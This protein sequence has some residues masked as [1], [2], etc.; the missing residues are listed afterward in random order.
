MAIS[1]PL[2]ISQFWDDLKLMAGSTEIEL[3]AFRKQSVDGAGNTLSSG[4]AVGKWGADLLVAPA[5]YIDSGKVEAMFKVLLGRDGT[6][7]AYDKRRPGPA[8]D[9]TGAILGAATVLISSKGSNNRSLALKGL[10][11]GY[12][13]TK[14]DRGSVSYAG[15]KVFYFEFAESGNANGSG[16]TAELEV[17]PFLPAAL[18][19]NDIVTLIKPCGKFKIV[20]G[21]YR[22]AT[23]DGALSG[24]IGF[25]VISTP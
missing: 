5:H 25:S 1:F 3:R 11:A 16:V 20:A 24:G 22:P 17:Q 7:L 8:A 19:V 18:A 15:G 21:S 14:G 9:P 12:S 13:L 4:R 2:S 23:G 10:P 6:F